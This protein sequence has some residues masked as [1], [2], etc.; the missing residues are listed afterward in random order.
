MIV[1]N[2]CIIICKGDNNILLGS[3]GDFYFFVE[4]VDD[5]YELLF[6]FEF[7]VEKN[8]FVYVVDLGV[9]CV[10]VFEW[11]VVLLWYLFY[12]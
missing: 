5:I 8:V 3:I 1:S 12:E 4:Y 10:E 6:L 11:E 7:V 2:D 9:E